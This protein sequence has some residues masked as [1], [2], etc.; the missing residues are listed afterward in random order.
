M[1]KF[2]FWVLALVGL[3]SSMVMAQ[4]PFP[5]R[6]VLAGEVAVVPKGDYILSKQAV[7]RVG[8]KLIL[9]AGVSIKVQIGLPIQVYGEMEVQGRAGEPVT[10]G[11]DSNGVCGTIAVYPTAGSPRPRLIANYLDLLHTKDSTSI[12]L[13][14]CDFAISNSR[15]TNRSTA[16]NRACVAV[17]NNSAGTISSCFIDGSSDTLKTP[18]SAITMDSSGGACDYSDTLFT[19]LQVILKSS[20]QFT[21]ASGSAE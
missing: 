17:T 16:A 18:I 20:K 4:E 1:T 8:G 3:C 14:G 11:P 7:V 13:S 5:V 19:N 12:L 2:V 9:E 6:T 10:I 21:L 15:I